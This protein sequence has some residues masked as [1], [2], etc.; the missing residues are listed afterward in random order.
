MSPYKTAYLIFLPFLAVAAVGQAEVDEPQ[1][2]SLIRSLRVGESPAIEELVRVGKP[3][4]PALLG[5]VQSE[6]P[7]ARYRA[8]EVLGRMGADASDVLEDI[9]EAAPELGG[10]ELP[11]LIRAVG[12]LLPYRES[13]IPDLDS[14]LTPLI[15][16][17]LAP[18]QLTTMPGVVC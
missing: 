8:I 7:P 6:R 4:V 2:A 5:V 14:T 1:L 13:G 10:T 16:T 15:L 18:N 3:A 12:N 9:L 11:V 17:A